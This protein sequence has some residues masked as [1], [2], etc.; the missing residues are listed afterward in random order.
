MNLDTTRLGQIDLLTDAQ[1]ALLTAFGLNLIYAVVILVVAFWFSGRVQ[2][3]V[4]TLSRR[5]KQ[6]DDT[7]FQFLATVLRYAILIVAVIFVL[8][9]FGIQTTSLIA[10]LGAAGLAIGLAVQGSLSNIAAGVM[11]VIFRPFRLGDFVRAAGESG[12]V[13]V[14]SLFTTELASAD[15]VKIILPNSSVW[16]QSIINYSVYPTRR[17]EWTFPVSYRADLRRAEAIIREIVFSDPRVLSEPAPLVQI[18]RLGD[19]SVDFLVH[20]WVERA[21][22]GPFQ[23]DVNR[24]IKEAFDT[25]GIET[26]YPSGVP[27]PSPAK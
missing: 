9:R 12:T 24:R 2:M 4:S 18:Q 19:V 22:L 7:L 8:N 6:I 3:R 10:I 14:I 20:A 26:T 1:T 27:R 13:K 11:L 25:G 16:G 5:H 17:A 21:Q 23:A 15:N